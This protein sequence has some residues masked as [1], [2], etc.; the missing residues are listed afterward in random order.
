ML[1]LKASNSFGC[2]TET[3]KVLEFPGSIEEQT[4]SIES[5]E[6]MGVEII[7]SGNQLEINTSASGKIIE[8]VYLHDLHG[9]IVYEGS[10]DQTSVMIDLSALSSAIYSVEVRSTFQSYQQL[11]SVY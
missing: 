8:K 7:N 9:R 1:T 2:E 5:I 4:T 6:S 10:F 3:Y 11:I